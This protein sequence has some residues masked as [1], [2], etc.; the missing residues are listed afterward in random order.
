MKKIFDELNNLITSATEYKASLDK[1][2]KNIASLSDKII[3]YDKSLYPGL[4]NNLMYLY[5]TINKTTDFDIENV[6]E[7]VNYIK[8]KIL[9]KNKQQ[10]NAKLENAMVIKLN[11]SLNTDGKNCEIVPSTPDILYRGPIEE[12]T[13]VYNE[14]TKIG[15]II[16]DD[17]PVH[18]CILR[19]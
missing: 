5:N 17:C 14:L 10:Q 9:K 16:E 1:M 19:Y 4:Y 18:F 11:Y 7:A 2:N 15:T 8:C 6:K 13:K 3:A 12:A